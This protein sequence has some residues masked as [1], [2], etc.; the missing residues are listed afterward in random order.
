MPR[1]RIRKALRIKLLYEGAYVCAICQRPGCHI[2][3]IDGNHSNNAEDNLIVLCV[4]H[5]DEAHTRR[6]LSQNLDAA[7]LRHAKHQWTEQIRARREALATVSGQTAILGEASFLAIGLAWGYINHR[8]VGQLANPDLRNTRDREIFEYCRSNGLIDSAGILIKPSTAQPA[9]SYID[10]SVYDWYRHGDDQRLHRV[11]SAFV[12]QISRSAHPVHLDRNAWAKSTIRELLRPG[13]FLFVEKAFY[14]KAVRETNDNQHRRCRTF[15]RKIDVEFFV[16]TRNM[17]G[18]TSMTVSFA[19]H[20][21][22]AA[23]LQLKSLEDSHGWLR[24]HCTPF[25]L[26][27]GFSKDASD[28]VARGTP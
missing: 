11:Y 23:L 7:A 10:G 14:F 6:T 20:Q 8:R 24:L 13:Q 25:S 17:F 16:D 28:Q 4:A 3:H 5:H 1:Q 27:V 15:A 22:S 2:H 26:G 12:D 21:T 9:T 19:G 18:T